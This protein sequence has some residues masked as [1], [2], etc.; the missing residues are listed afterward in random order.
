[1]RLLIAS[2]NRGKIKEIRSIVEGSV[3]VLSPLDLSLDLS[4]LEDGNT[5]KENAIK[6]AILYF[7]ATGIVTL[8]EDTGLEVDF[9]RGRPGIYSARFS[10]GGDAENRTKLLDRLGKTEN[11]AARFRTVMVLALKDN[12]IECF[13]GILEGEI[14]REEKGSGGFGYDSVFIPSGFKETLAEMS[15]EEKNKISHRRLALNK[16]LDFLERE[17]ERVEEL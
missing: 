9:L 16:V 5:L 15:Y 2:K 10:G 11:R 8:G 4:I 7:K 1:M 17:Q 3:K 12:W 13:E 14:G 6:K